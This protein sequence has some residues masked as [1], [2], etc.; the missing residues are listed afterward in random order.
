MKNIL[1]IFLLVIVIIFSGVFIV[2]EREV[3]VITGDSNTAKVY[4]TGVHWHLP[5]Y[6]NFSYIYMNQRDSYLALT[7]TPNNAPQGSN[8][9]N[10]A[11]TWQVIDAIKYVKYLNQHSRKDF[12]KNMADFV[13]GIILDSV[14]KSSSDQ[15]LLRNLHLSQVNIVN[16]DTGIAIKSINAL[17][18]SQVNSSKPDYSESDS[19][20]LIESTYNYA[21]QIKQD[22]DKV[23]QAVFD[24][25]RQ[26]NRRFYDYF[27][28]INYYQAMAESKD[29]VPSFE[30][31]YK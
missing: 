8:I 31:L 21:L 11:I 2:D 7:I 6:G 17:G 3:A 25:L 20:I 18:L 24:Q 28:K 19:L 29:D 14:A 4:S 27:S 22:A 5:M 16:P 9:I 13:S 1:I 23:Q 10:V 15:Q 26:R 30:Q 12:D